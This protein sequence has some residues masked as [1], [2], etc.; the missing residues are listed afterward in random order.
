MHTESGVPKGQRF[1]SNE[2]VKTALYFEIYVLTDALDSTWIH[3]RPRAVV[4]VL[5]YA[6]VPYPLQPYASTN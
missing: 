1:C 6:E 5:R 3:I 2:G 4:S